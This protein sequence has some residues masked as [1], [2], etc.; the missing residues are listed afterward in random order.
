MSESLEYI[1]R[2]FLGEMDANEKKTFEDRCIRDPAFA[3]EVAVYV[4][5]QEQT[6]QQW[7]EQKSREFDALATEVSKH[8]VVGMRD[9]KP[10]QGTLRTLSSWRYAA[11]AAS[12]VI[13]LAL[14]VVVYLQ[15]RKP[16]AP[17]I[18]KK[19]PD[20]NQATSGADSLSKPVMDSV[21]SIDSSKIVP[22]P[23]H[24]MEVYEQLASKNFQPD[25][26]PGNTPQLIADASLEYEK[27]NYKDAISAYKD[28]VAMVEEF[29]TRSIDDEQEAKERREILFYARYYTALSYFADGN[30]PNAIAAF[31]SVGSAPD[32]YWQNKARW[33]LALAYLKTG[34]V[35]EARALLEQVAADSRSR[36][37]KKKA[38]DL[39]SEI[40]AGNKDN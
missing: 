33:Y 22:L 24:D 36:N 28:A 30:A 12:V 19:Q 26:L 11:I 13:I 27:G 25:K 29:E 35:S 23:R 20:Q 6:E 5:M 15:Y 7:K 18:A 34:R 17:A 32:R 1:E 14:S 2:Y 16:D 21:T 39:L 37:Y 40:L 10:V 8:R 3:R 31:K 38:S 4:M 9:S